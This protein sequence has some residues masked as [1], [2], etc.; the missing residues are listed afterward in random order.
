[1]K[2]RTAKRSVA[3]DMLSFR[4]LRGKPWL[5]WSIRLVFTVVALVWLVSRI[6][7]VDLGPVTANLSLFVVFVS[8]ILQLTIRLLAAGQ[9]SFGMRA[10][11]MHFRL[12]ELFTI[13]M[14][15]GFYSLVL[16]GDLAGGLVG[17]RRLSRRDRKG[18][19]VGALLIYLRLI[20]TL[21]LL[22]F[23][24]AGIWFAPIAIAP[25]LRVI[26]VLMA[27]GLILVALPFFS[28]KVATAM[29]KISVKVASGLPVPA[30]L[31]RISETAW[32]SIRAFHSLAHPSSLAV[33]V[34]ISI[35]SQLLGVLSIT[36]LTT[37]LG[38]GVPLFA[39]IWIRSAI[40]LVQMLP[41]S[42]AGIGV[43]EISLVAL[44][45]LYGVTEAQALTLSLVLLG[46][47]LIIGFM[48]GLFELRDVLLRRRQL[49][50]DRLAA[51]SKE[52]L[53]VAA[54]PDT[55]QDGAAVS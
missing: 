12:A 42:L 8:V 41:I 10:L 7:S 6:R 18:V 17:W 35:A 1:M 44:L 2:A 23:G 11:R 49:K 5:I 48:G 33:L 30:S 22:L 25:I 29:E 27:L 34:S 37:M 39:L 26:V 3:G 53:V 21:S 28:P 45:Y 20:N 32:Q 13:T 4:W 14:I 50:K 24:L 55:Y 46:T 16:P 36:L 9:L 52:S 54:T 43:R 47:R 15:S 40:T 31:L 38:I 19:E 51:G